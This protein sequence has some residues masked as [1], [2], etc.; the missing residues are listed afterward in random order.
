LSLLDDGFG[1]TIFNGKS[2]FHVDAFLSFLIGTVEFD[3][4]AIWGCEKS[5][6]IWVFKFAV[7]F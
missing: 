6:E 1:F 2:I 3:K 5:V 7:I 4:L